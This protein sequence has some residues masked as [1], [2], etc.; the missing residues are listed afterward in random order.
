M[1]NDEKRD[2]EQDERDTPIEND[3]Y[4]DKDQNKEQFEEFSTDQP[5]F[6]TD[7]DQNLNSDLDNIA[8]ENIEFNEKT[9]TFKPDDSQ[10][11]QKNEIKRVDNFEEFGDEKEEDIVDP[12]FYEEEDNEDEEDDLSDSGYDP[13]LGVQKRDD[14]RLK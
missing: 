13:E 12:D 5:Q 8:V 3:L 9:N 2:F 6:N 10:P 4:F 11:D 1:E 7:E 14:S